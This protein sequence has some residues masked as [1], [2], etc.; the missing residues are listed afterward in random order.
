MRKLCVAALCGAT[1]G[2]SGCG[3]SLSDAQ[4]EAEN[5]PAATRS[6]IRINYDPSNGVLPVPNDLLFSG[7]TDGTLAIPVDDPTD[8][9]DPYVALSALDGWGTTSP[10]GISVT[11]PEDVALDGASVA[12]PGSVQLFEVELGGPLTASSD[13]GCAALPSLS[14]CSLGEALTFGVD[15]VSQAK[16]DT[17]AIV[18]LKP[19][20]PKHSYLLVVTNQIKDDAGRS[21]M[22]SSTYAL[23]K[24]DINTHPLGSESQLQLQGLINM[25][26]A[27]A[28]T[29]GVDPASIVYSGV[30]TTQ[31]VTDVTG[32]ARLLI[33]E[34][35]QKAQSGQNS[36]AL[37][38]LGNHPAYPLLS[39]SKD[40]LELAGRLDCDNPA[41][42]QSCAIASTAQVK[43]STL[44]LPYLLSY[45]TTANCSPA[46]LQTT[47]SCAGLNSHWQ[48]GAASPLTVLGALQA[49]PALIELIAPQCPGVDFTDPDSSVVA[50]AIVASGCDPML[51]NPADPQQLVAMDADKHLTRYN[52]LPMIREWRDAPVLVTLPDVDTVNAIRAQQAGI[53]VAQL[54]AAGGAL[55]KPAT[56]WPVVIFV[57]GITSDKEVMHAIAGTL[58]YAGIAAIAIDQP[59]HGERAAVLDFGQ[60]EP[61]TLSATTDTGGSA[62]VYANLG[63]LLTVRDNLRQSSLDLL[64]L[65]ASINILSA[66]EVQVLMSAPTFDATQVSLLGHSLGASVAVPGVAIA[67]T[68]LLLPGKDQPEASNPFTFSTASLAMPGSGLGGVFGTS[69]GFGPL[70]E[71]GLTAT[72]NFKQA[73]AEGAGLTLAEFEALAVSNPQMYATI[74]AAAYP[75]F[76]SQFHF[77]AQSIIESGDAINWTPLIS[78]Y[79]PKHLMFEVVGDGVDNLPDQSIPNA[80]L[81][82]GIHPSLSGTVLPL[83]GTEPLASLLGLADGVDDSVSDPAGVAALVRYSKGHHSSLLDPS[84][85][86]ADPEQGIP[87]DVACDPAATAATTAEMQ[88]QIAQYVAS[89][90]TA[91]VISNRDVIAPP[92]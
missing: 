35:L 74:V 64:S 41:Y 55:E 65:R 48:G 60:G 63:S 28:A 24:Q 80:V 78:A 33:A 7:S 39:T 1:L 21:I 67:N 18:P 26:E 45:P 62:L 11:L 10:F 66:I 75:Q 2:L 31:S 36:L 84:A 92:M 58:A 90:G 17:I 86:C 70:V 88:S 56:G 77:A 42:A 6:P 20:Q 5:N 68:P 59:L 40:A 16:G 44:T 91:L 89:Q 15:Y 37:A 34:E 51:P 79:T 76:F 73:A 13:P 83:S 38:P 69:V 29:A 85:V 3:E 19:L 14:I 23:V 54:I 52:P 12:M 25:Y 57:H 71:A 72:D 27:T 50:Q 8:V 82:T 4:A 47:G 53:S 30:F 32:Y 22:P 81:G 9:S 49:N 61:I 43:T 46:D 87:V